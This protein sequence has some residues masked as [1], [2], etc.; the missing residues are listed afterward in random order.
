[1][2]RLLGLKCA[3]RSRIYGKYIKN[4]E[5]NAEKKEQPMSEIYAGK[6]CINF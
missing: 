2:V 3:S 1:M 6:H 4:L 5:H